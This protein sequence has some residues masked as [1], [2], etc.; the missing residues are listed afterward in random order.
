[1]SRYFKQCSNLSQTD[2]IGPAN[3]GKTANHTAYVTKDLC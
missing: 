3:G 1:M 2:G